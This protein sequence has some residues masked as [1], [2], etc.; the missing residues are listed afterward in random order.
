VSD[1][2]EDAGWR[3]QTYDAREDEP[4]RGRSNAPKTP[5]RDVIDAR[6]RSHSRNHSRAPSPFQRAQ[7]HAGAAETEVYIGS[8][9]QGQGQSQGYGFSGHGAYGGAG[10][11]AQSPPQYDASGRLFLDMSDGWH[12]DMAWHGVCARCSGN[13]M[14]LPDLLFNAIMSGHDQCLRQV[15]GYSPGDPSAHQPTAACVRRVGRLARL[16]DSA[17]RFPMHVAAAFGASQCM[18]TMLEAGAPPGLQD[19]DGRG[20][21]HYAAAG[22]SG[23]CVGML[24]DANYDLVGARDRSGCTALHLAA[25]FGAV[26]AVTMLLHSAAE[27]NARNVYGQ[28]PLHL[29]RTATALHELL[30]GG[31]DLSAIDSQGFLPIHCAAAASD[32]EVLGILCRDHPAQVNA[33]DSV[34]SRSALHV[35][36]DAGHREAC[37]LLLSV[38]ADPNLRD[39][40]GCTPSMLAVWRGHTGVASELEA[41]EGG[42]QLRSPRAGLAPSTP[43]GSGLAATMSRR[44][45]R[46]GGGL[47]ALT[48]P[49][50]AT[51]PDGLVHVY[52]YNPYSSVGGLAS[53][54][55]SV[56]SMYGYGQQAAPGSGAWGWQGQQPLQVHQMPPHAQMQPGSRS[57]SRRSS[58]VPAPYAPASPAG[59]PGAPGRPPQGPQMPG[60][61]VTAPPPPPPPA[62]ADSTLFNHTSDAPPPPPPAPE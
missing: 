25:Q 58:F 19:A 14:T 24:I 8:Y 46:I 17:A 20:A 54:R 21:I 50:V 6:S 26:D 51:D 45:S 7:Q 29:V 57:V 47:G 30:A 48:S 1:D 37:A 61:S 32:L 27:T 44:E 35:A 38:G 55:E 16:K 39:A 18:A 22:G 53:R 4:P 28:T 2:D 34:G 12:P 60:R 52:G 43:A 41:A 3:R 59:A 40:T 9:G 31:G 36:A 11:N 15:I 5:A 42:A 49:V 10:A 23:D 56:S 33:V 13:M 62:T